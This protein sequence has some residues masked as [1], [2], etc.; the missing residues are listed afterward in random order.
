MLRIL[1]IIILF[2]LNLHSENIS[3]YGS[4]DKALAEAQAEKKDMMILLVS[5]RD[6][7]SHKLLKELFINQEYIEYINKTFITILI[8]VEYKSSYPIELFYTTTFPSLFFASYKDESFLTHPL[9]GLEKK[10][11]FLKVLNKIKKSYK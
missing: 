1:L 6:K 3:W 2:V 10:S 8:N 9:Y 7:S 4:Y 5:N 11:D